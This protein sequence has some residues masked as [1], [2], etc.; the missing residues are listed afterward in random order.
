MISLTTFSWKQAPGRARPRRWWAGCC[1]SSRRVSPS[2]GSLR[3]PL[4][5]RPPANSASGSRSISNARYA[6]RRR[7]SSRRGARRHSAV[8]DAGFIGTIHAFCGRLLRDQALEAGIVPTFD[9]VDEVQF[10]LLTAAAW[11]RWVER[12]RLEDH[13]T[14][15]HLAELGIAPTDLRP[16]FSLLVENP[17]V[18]LP[19][20]PVPAPDPAPCRAA[21]TKLLAA[22]DGLM[23]REEPEAG[24]DDLQ[25]LVHRFRYHADVGGVDD[26]PEFAAALATMTQGNCKATQNRWSSSKRREG[27]GEGAWDRVRR[28]PHHARRRLSA[29]MVRPSSCHRHGCAA[30]GRV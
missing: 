2:S 7:L 16:G 9:E 26:L 3:S 10:K 11:Q 20:E 8:F 13:A 21:L 29:R 18:T 25:S 27:S 30:V 15:Q 12:A 23:P 22:A 4:P 19:H 14:L 1:R 28:I 17:D 5:A 24:W 6:K